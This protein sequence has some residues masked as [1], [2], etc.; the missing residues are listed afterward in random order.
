[1]MA[2]DTPIYVNN[3]QIENVEGYIYLGQRY[4]TRDKT[5]DKEIQRRITAGWTAFVKHRAI[6]KGNIGKCLK[7]QVYN[8][9]ILPAMTYVE[10]TWALTTQAKKKLAAAQTK[11]ERSMLNII[12]RNSNTNIWVREKTKITDVIEQVRRRKWT[13]AGQGIQQNR[14]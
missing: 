4:S 11:M 5:K 12:Y 7:R 14:R 8:S 10:E 1:M 9:C 3:T 2:N 6:F 13:W